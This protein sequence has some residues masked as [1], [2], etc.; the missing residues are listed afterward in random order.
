VS[1]FFERKSFFWQLF[2]VT[3][4][5]WQKNS[6][7]KFARLTL[8]MKLTANIFGHYFYFAFGEHWQVLAES[9]VSRSLKKISRYNCTAKWFSDAYCVV[10]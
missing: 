5:L 10:S 2:L 3:F 7:E 4:W 6:N 9:L 1:A 8:M